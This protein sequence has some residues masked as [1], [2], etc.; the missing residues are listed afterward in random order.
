MTCVPNVR[1]RVAEMLAEAAEKMPEGI[2]LKIIEGFRPLSQQRFM[3]A[4]VRKFF[5]EQHPEWDKAT[6][7]SPD[8]PDVCSARR[9]LPTA[10]LD[11][12][13]VRH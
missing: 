5:A 9:S 13:R 7:Q 12:G 6:L 8:E 3:Y 11:G 2:D 1:K 4:E 10:A